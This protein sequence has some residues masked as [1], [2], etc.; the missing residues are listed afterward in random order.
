MRY[1]FAALAMVGVACFGGESGGGGETSSTAA[2][3]APA[4]RMV[5]TEQGEYRYVPDQ[6]TIKVGDTVRWLNES[7]PPHN[8]AF[9]AD[10]IPGGAADVLNGAMPDRMGNLAGPL[11]VQVGTMYEISFVGAPAGEYGYFCTPHEML[12][13]VATL[14][15]EQ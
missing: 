11:L 7:G 8:V 14:T 9:Y 13:M 15:I 4:E 12:G 3:A 6:L 1:F 10:R 2:A 5:L